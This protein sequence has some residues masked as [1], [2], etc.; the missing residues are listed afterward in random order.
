MKPAPLPE[1]RNGPRGGS[2][3][4]GAA[5]RSRAVACAYEHP[6]ATRC[7]PIR[8]TIAQATRIAMRAKKSRERAAAFM[9]AGG[10]RRLGG[11]WWLELSPVRAVNIDRGRRCD[12]AGPTEKELVPASWRPSPAGSR[13]PADRC[14]RCPQAEHR[15]VPYK[16]SGQA[17]HTVMQQAQ[18]V[19]QLRVYR[20]GSSWGRLLPG[21]GVRMHVAGQARAGE[22]SQKQGRPQQGS[23]VT[24]MSYEGGPQASGCHDG[25]EGRVQQRWSCRKKNIERITNK[26]S[27]PHAGLGGCT[28]SARA[29]H[30][31]KLGSA[32]VWSQSA[33]PAAR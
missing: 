16:E 2:A 26:V 33:N 22:N 12:R 29:P 17:V 7:H 5:A 28:L 19:V 25:L 3:E 4:R 20:G 27:T 21:A 13:P 24:R 18:R 8:L 23:R 10:W 9:V 31:D 15:R 6:A 1:P 11:G 30:S 32:K 14:L